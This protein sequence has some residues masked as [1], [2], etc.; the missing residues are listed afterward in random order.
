MEIQSNAPSGEFEAKTV[1][2]YPGQ[3]E[4]DP[5]GQ[6]VRNIDLKRAVDYNRV[7]RDKIWRHKEHDNPAS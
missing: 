4:G 5:M 7:I 1:A 3:R 2:V 6:A